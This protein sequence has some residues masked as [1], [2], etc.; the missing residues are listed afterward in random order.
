[1]NIS[2]ELIDGTIHCKEGAAV[3]FLENLYQSLTNRP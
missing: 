2:N 1:M 3:L